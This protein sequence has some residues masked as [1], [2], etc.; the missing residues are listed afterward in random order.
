[1]LAELVSKEMQS[2]YQ[3]GRADGQVLGRDIADGWLVTHGLAV[4]VVRMEGWGHMI[5]PIR[6]LVT[7]GL[8]VSVVD[9]H[10]LLYTSPSP[11]D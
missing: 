3:R 10:C 6:W 9:D 8:A 1:M 2:W 11:R 5:L 7:H 4:S